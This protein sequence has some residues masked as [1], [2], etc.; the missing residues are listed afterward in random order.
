MSLI[1]KKPSNRAKTTAGKERM[2]I[3]EVSN[4][5]IGIR[6]LF[7]LSFHYKFLIQFQKL[8]KLLGRVA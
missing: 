5:L 8:N 4:Y 7:S 2:D 1:T 3:A 6:K